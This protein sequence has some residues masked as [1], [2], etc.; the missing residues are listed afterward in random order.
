MRGIGDGYFRNVR[1]TIFLFRAELFKH[2]A[3]DHSFNVGNPDNIGMT[4]AYFFDE[5]KVNE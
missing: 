4:L 1:S 2:M 5:V 3:V